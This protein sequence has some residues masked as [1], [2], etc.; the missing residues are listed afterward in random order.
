M[1]K[2]EYPLVGCRRQTTRKRPS[3]LLQ[4]EPTI[5]QLSLIKYTDSEGEEQKFRLITQVQNQC[6]DLGIELGLEPATVTGLK[7]SH[8]SSLTEFCKAVLQK[9][10]DGGRDVTWGKLLQTL[11][12]IEAG[13]SANHLRRALNA[14]FK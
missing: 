4:K 12:D 7:R 3:D 5:R 14:F 2:L 6:Q 9:W 11:T 1:I 13:G 8:G 10:I